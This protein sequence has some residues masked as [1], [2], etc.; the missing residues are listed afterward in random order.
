VPTQE[1]ELRT[2][3][4]PIEECLPDGT[5]NPRARGWSRHPV[6][7]CNL[8]GPWGRVKRWEYWS[9]IGGGK[10]VAITYA[11]VDYLGIVGLWCCDLATGFEVERSIA[12]PLAPGIE[13]GPRVDRGRYAWDGLGLRV[14]IDEQPDRTLLRGGFTDRRH[15]AVEVDLS[16]ARSEGHET[17]N[18]LIPW[19][20]RRFQFTSKQNTRPA[21]GTARV[22][23]RE[24]EFGPATDAFGTLDH[25]RGLWPYSTRWNW[26]A[27]SGTVDG[28][29][30]GLQFG[31]KWTEGT[32]FTEN[33]LCVDGRLTKIG[34]E[35]RWDYSWD[36][37]MRP[38]R[39]TAPTSGAVDLRMTPIHDRH[40]ATKLG[41]L[42]TE[43]HQVFGHWSGS[44]RTDDGD[45]IAIGADAHLLGFAEE[46]RSRW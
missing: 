21:T 32:G 4:E 34:E 17:L 22:G 2:D 30:V 26:A 20:D 40:R 45:E 15:G 37:P 18:V 42:S 12:L 46:S 38:W 9:V 6:L 10:T 3:G 35:L 43:V 1:H 13:L 39:V 24:W 5:L 7:T 31:G 33:A 23:G 36:D 27:A 28:R 25:G 16:V 29:V 8:R 11:D 19:S 41:V 44:V 14:E